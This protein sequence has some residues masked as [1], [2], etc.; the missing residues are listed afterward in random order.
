MS[1]DRKMNTVLKYPGSKWSMTDWI[2]SN[3][4]P[5]FE[6]MTYLEPY[7]GSGAVFF[8]KR[9]SIIET[10]NDLDGNVV[11]LFRVIREHPEELA[12]LVAFTPWSRLEYRNS[13]KQTGDSLE[14]A[15]RFLVRMWMAIGAKSSDITGWRHWIVSNCGWAESWVTKLPS[16]IIQISSRLQNITGHVV[17]IEN[18]E[19]IKLIKRFKKSRV[20]IY[21]CEMTD[22]DHIAFL[23]TI[24]QHPGPVQISGYD[25]EMYQ[26]VLQGWHIEQKKFK[27]ESGKDRI[28]TLWMNYKPDKRQLDLFL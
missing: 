26:G 28:E 14:D 6:K 18:Q 24:V 23:E 11:N 8:N 1:G 17:Q 19:S 13:Y 12:N 22:E 9:R 4:P 21:A 7:F 10:I 20:F 5:G 3:F 15:R 16:N 25:N 27:C 2:I